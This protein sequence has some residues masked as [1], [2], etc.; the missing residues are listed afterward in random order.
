MRGRLRAW[1]P[2]PHLVPLHLVL[3][4]RDCANQACSPA[5]SLGNRLL[6]FTFL[7]TLELLTL[8]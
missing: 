5:E 7:L 1:I 2:A 8:K 3:S 4:A 6:N